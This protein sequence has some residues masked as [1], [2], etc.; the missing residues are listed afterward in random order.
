MAEADR[1][2]MDIKDKEIA[3]DENQGHFRDRKTNIVI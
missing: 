2:R 1:N 3:E